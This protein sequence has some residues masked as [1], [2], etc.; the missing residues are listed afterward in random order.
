[1]VS[2][3]RRPL[4]TAL[5]PDEPPP[6]LDVDENSPWLRVMGSANT[7]GPDEAGRFEAFLH[8]LTCV[9]R[10]HNVVIDAQIFEG[11]NARAGVVLRA[12][13]PLGR[14]STYHLDR[15]RVVFGRRL[16]FG[17]SFFERILGKG[18]PRA[19]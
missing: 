1:M 9:T 8:D 2:E 11:R 6:D 7:M 14:S 18:N 5:M 19:R 15:G 4:E 16:P 12:L 10:R 3:P 13:A 17:L